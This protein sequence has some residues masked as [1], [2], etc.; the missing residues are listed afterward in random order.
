MPTHFRILGGPRQDNGLYVEIDTGQSN[1]RLL[2]DC[3]EGIP[4]AIPYGDVIQLNHL[5]LS[6]C[7]MDHVTGLSAF[8][9]RVYA[10]D[11]QTPVIWGPLGTAVHVQHQLRAFLWNLTSDATNVFLVNDVAELEVIT[12]ELRLSEGYAVLRELSRSPRRDVLLTGDGFDVYAIEMD[13][14][15]PSLSFVV[16]EHTRSNIDTAKLASMGLRPGPWMKQL[17]SG[18]TSDGTVEVGG[19]PTSIESLRE[20]LLVQTLGVSVAYCT[21]FLLDDAAESRLVPLLR[22][23]DTLVCESQYRRDDAALALANRHMTCTQVARLARQAGVGKLVLIHV[24]DRYDAAGR[25][26]MLAEARAEFPF[27]D[28]PE[29]WSVDF[30]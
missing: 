28:F 26:E 25:R 7:H 11:R 16:R 14:G 4:T 27:T 19:T 13:H 17:K 21:D 22:G 9:R 18:E 6:H 8:V 2:F 30:W 29:S 10:S 5:F 15:T 23:V 1:A 3:G 24:S 20:Q 12:Y